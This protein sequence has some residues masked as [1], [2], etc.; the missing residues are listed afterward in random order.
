MGVTRKFDVLFCVLRVTYPLDGRFV[1]Y[2]RIQL[3]TP[4]LDAKSIS[5]VHL[6]PLIIR[7]LIEIRG[8]QGPPVSIA[9]LVLE[10][11]EPEHWLK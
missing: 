3:I 8:L 7:D 2:H 1:V 6:V 11:V 10:Y 5:L 9:V 4:A